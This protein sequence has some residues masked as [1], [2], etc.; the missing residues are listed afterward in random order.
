MR[1]RGQ[2]GFALLLVF[3]MAAAISITLYVQIPRVAFQAQRQKEQLLMERGEQYQRAIQLFVRANGRYPGKI[4]DLENFNN[5]RF[6]RHKFKDPIT[7]KEE[8]RLIHVNAAGVFTDSLLNKKKE[9]DPKEV[10]STEG[11][12]VGVQ[13]GIGVT[14]LPGQQNAANP[15]LRRRA[16][17]GGPNNAIGPDGQVAGIQ[18]AGIAPMPP[19]PGQPYPPGQ[20]NPGAQVQPYPGAPQQQPVLGMPIPPNQSQFPGGQP[21]PPEVSSFP[22]NSV[23]G[24]PIQNRLPFP[25]QPQAGFQPGVPQP[26]FQQPGFQQP[27]FQQPGQPGFQQPGF[28]QPGSQQPGGNQSSVGTSTY[29][30]GNQPYVGGSQPY[31]G[32]GSSVGSQPSGPGAPG[33][34]Q[35]NPNPFPQPVQNFGQQ[36]LPGGFPQPGLPQQNFPQPN[37]PQPQANQ[38]QFNQPVPGGG[39]PPQGGG[40]PNAATQ[41][42][43][44]ILTTPRQGGLPGAQ[45]AG[46]QVG[47]GIAGVASTSENPAIMVYNERSSYNEWEFIFDFSK[48]RGVANPNVGGVIGTPASQIGTVAGAVPGASGDGA[49]PGVGGLGRNTQQSIGAQLGATPFGGANPAPNPAGGQAPGGSSQGQVPA[50]IRMGRP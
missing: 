38:G 25:N 37:F 26:G 5:R 20:N 1:K 50:N 42:I 15:A 43:Q 34:I 45:P 16:S 14:P 31:V 24:Q 23:P 13:A 12:Y 9:G 48:Q 8:W 46:Q 11:Q 19:M 21:L 39:F 3:L 22:T 27:G 32:G 44:N 47:G 30:G 40:A 17:E 41:L 49:G 7:G 2:S 33:L 10:S 28:Q 36:G 6:L 29:V 18:G 4:E 35:G